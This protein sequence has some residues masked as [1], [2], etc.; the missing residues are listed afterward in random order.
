MKQPIDVIAE[1]IGAHEAAAVIDLLRE[2]GWLIFRHDA[3]RLAQAHEREFYNWPNSGG[4]V[5]TTTS[6]EVTF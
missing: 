5:H 4:Y 6:G 1:R 2:A 3:I